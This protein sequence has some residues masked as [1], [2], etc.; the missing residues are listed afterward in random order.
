MAGEKISA[1]GIKKIFYG[2]PL[3]VVATPY[4]DG[5][6]DTGLSA[7]ELKAFLANAS[8]KQV[9]NVHQGTWNY[10]K[11][12]ATVTQYKN[13]LTKKTYRQSVEGGD[14]TITFS[15]GKYDLEVKADFE[16][17]GSNATKYS[18]P[19]DYKVENMTI[20]GL[21]ED[22]VYIVFPKASVIARGAS[23]DEA[24]AIAVTATPLE[25]DIQI[26]PEVWMLKSAVDSAV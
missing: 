18:A 26:E 7:K 11:A 25:P 15:I 3:A 4:A 16:G 19:L 24:I 23:T 13:Q 10:E 21:T 17:G 12:E 1:I 6:A 22:D 2:A 14:S 9:E 5:N 20:A 8:T